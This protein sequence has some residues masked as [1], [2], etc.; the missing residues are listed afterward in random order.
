YERLW[1]EE[2][3]Y[4]NREI[5]ETSK[6]FASALS[7]LGIEVGDRVVVLLANCPEVLVSYPA[8]W[9]IGAVVIPVLHVLEAH[10]LAFI[11]KDSAA[12]AVI[13]SH[14][15]VGKVQEAAGLEKLSGVN[16]I[17]VTEGQAEV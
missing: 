10:E 14:D 2:R 12:K 15:L 8:I 17:A 6:R 3:S 9:R 7:N 1:F 11:L 13:T 5:L 4:T 16:I